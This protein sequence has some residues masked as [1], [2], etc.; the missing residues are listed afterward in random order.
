M[1]E[2]WRPVVGYEGRYEVSSLGRVRSCTRVV[3]FGSQKR[4]A[5]GR[6]LSPSTAHRYL[7][8]NLS[9]RPRR[10]HLLVLEAFVGLR[11]QGM[12][13]RH[14][15]GDPTDNRIANLAWG[16]RKEN[17]ADMVGHGTRVRGANVKSS[18]LTPEL[19]QLARA[20]CAGGESR[21]AVARSL[22]VS[23]SCIDDVV[24]GRTWRHV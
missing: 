3:A 5:V 24:N 17:S 4:T 9:R 14:L 10:V 8:V 12:V 23:G 13:A 22:G 16:T 2:E 1:P 6:V 15:N 21:A 7:S 19:V 20:R 18:K 11:P